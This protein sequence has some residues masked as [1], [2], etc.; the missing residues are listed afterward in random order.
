MQ[1][2][3]DEAA[4]RFEESARARPDFAAAYY[5]LGLARERQGR[6]DEAI[7]A[8][9]RLLELDPQNADGRNNLARVVARQRR[10]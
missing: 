10:R 2:K 1:G 7:A 6:D 3:L 8:Y 9:T 5:N 4:V